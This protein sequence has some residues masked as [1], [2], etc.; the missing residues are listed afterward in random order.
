MIPVEHLFL[1]MQN[2]ATAMKKLQN[3]LYQKE[4]S[5]DMSTISTDRKFQVHFAILT[6]VTICT[7]PNYVVG[8]KYEP[9]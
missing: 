2:K 4:F 5:K 8:G 1:Q 7:K 6:M 9:E 3:I